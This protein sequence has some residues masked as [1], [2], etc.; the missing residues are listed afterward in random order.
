LTKMDGS[1]RGGIAFPIMLDLDLPIYFMG[2]G[3]TIDSLIPFDRMSYL[4]SL[5]G[6]DEEFQI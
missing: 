3:E 2:V 1:A 6:I 4:K 5:V